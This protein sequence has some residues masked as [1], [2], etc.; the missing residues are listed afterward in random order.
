MLDDGDMVL[1]PHLDADYPDDGEL[2]NDAHVM[3]S[4]IY[5]LGF[6]GVKNSSNCLDFLRWWQQKLYDRC[7]IDHAAGYFVDQKFI[8][9]A[10]PLFDGFRVMTD[11]GYNVAYWNLMNREVTSRDGRWRANGGALRFV[12]FSGLDMRHEPTFSKHQQRFT[13]YNIG[14]LRSLVDDY[15]KCVAAN[16]QDRYSELAYAF[17]SFGDGEPFP[18]VLRRMYREDFDSERIPPAR[19]LEALSERS[20]E[21]APE[22]PHH[23]DM[24]I[25]RL[26]YRVWQARGDLQSAFDLREVDGRL[27]YC[28]WWA[29]SASRELGL[30]EEAQQELRRIVR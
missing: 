30:S 27:A 13:L 21:P 22:L 6:I 18:E 29:Y 15:R 19:R 23:P 25:T 3:K 5:N 12:H 7:V 26:M 11:P 9:Y 1:T 10:L 17:D 4:G 8:D 20:N 14:E 24:T 28:A 2:P 16:E